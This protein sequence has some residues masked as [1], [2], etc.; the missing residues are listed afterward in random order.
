MQFLTP[1]A[2]VETKTCPIVEQ[3]WVRDNKQLTGSPAIVRTQK[4]GP[5]D[6]SGPSY[7]FAYLKLVAG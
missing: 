3:K 4:L 1:Q 2:I 6:S 7:L 5:D